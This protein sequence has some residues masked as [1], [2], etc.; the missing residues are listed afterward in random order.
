[1]ELES[2]FIMTITKIVDGQEINLTTEEET[3]YS[4][5]QP[6]ASQILQQAKDLRL[7]ELDFF[8]Y[9]DNSVRVLTV[10]DTSTPPKPFYLSLKWEGRELVSEQIINLQTQIDLATILEEN[11]EFIY[12]QGDDSINIS[13]QELKSIYVAM[14]NIVNTNFVTYQAHIASIN[15]LTLVEDVESYDFQTGY[16]VNQTYNLT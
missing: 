15:N 16:L 5:N 12:M 14:M 3:E 4:N 8:H 9:N 13:F 7:K 1:M 11:A 6:S 2:K 10:F